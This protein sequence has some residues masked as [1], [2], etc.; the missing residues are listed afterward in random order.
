MYYSPKKAFWEDAIF[1]N[2][3]TLFVLSLKEMYFW[4]VGRLFASFR[5][6]VCSFTLGKDSRWLWLAGDSVVQRQKLD[7]RLKICWKF[8]TWR[9]TRQTKPR[10]NQNERSTVAVDCSSV[11][12]F[13]PHR[14]KGFPWLFTVICKKY[15][16]KNGNVMR[17]GEL[18]K[19]HI[20][21]FFIWCLIRPY[22]PSKM[23]PTDNKHYAG[24]RK[25]ETHKISTSLHF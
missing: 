21:F 6:F 14:K 15:N 2:I 11:I 5:L 20:S 17:R 24:E 18:N 25:K 1:I 16:S 19:Y 3:Y 12:E 7:S 23:F 10:E 13:S 22:K 9:Q 4:L 8:G